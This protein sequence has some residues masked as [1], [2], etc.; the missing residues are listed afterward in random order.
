MWFISAPYSL[1]DFGLK[2]RRVKMWKMWRELANAKYKASNLVLGLSCTPFL[3]LAKSPIPVL[4]LRWLKAVKDIS[5]PVYKK[6]I[7]LLSLS[8]LS[9]VMLGLLS[10]SEW[11]K[12]SLSLMGPDP[13]RGSEAHTRTI[14]PTGYAA[15]FVTFHI[16]GLTALRND[17][18][19]AWIT[20]VIND[21]CLSRSR[22]R[23]VLHWIHDKILYK[24]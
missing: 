24:R 22:S 10:T 2:R 11:R 15:C 9:W 19:T 1:W 7:E 12:I 17:K 6:H 18:G 21:I 20:A 5:P 8:A 4:S 23:H 3:S 13:N 16:I 14:E